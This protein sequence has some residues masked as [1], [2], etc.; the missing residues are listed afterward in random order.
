MNLWQRRFLGILT[1]GGS[2][3]GGVAGTGPLFAAATPVLGRILALVAVGLYSWGVWCGAQ[4]LEHSEDALRSNRAFWAIQIPYLISP[5][6][7][8]LFASGPLLYLTFQPF[9]FRFGFLGLLGSKFDYTLLQFDQ[10][11][12]VGANVFAIAVFLFLNRCLRRANVSSAA[13]DHSPAA[14]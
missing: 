5:V 11:F 10:P 8:Y 14:R 3:L 1:L 6:A 7:S 12:V 13:L 9:A 2:F 4:L